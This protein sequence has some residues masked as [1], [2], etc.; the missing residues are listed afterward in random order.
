MR[1]TQIDSVNSNDSYTPSI[2]K[3]I[4]CIMS[5]ADVSLLSTEIGDDV[6]QGEEIQ[7]ER[8]F[9]P[10]GFPLVYCPCEPFKLPQCMLVFFRQ[11]TTLAPQWTD[12]C[13]GTPST[14]VSPLGH[15]QVQHNCWSRRCASVILAFSLMRQMGELDEGNIS[16]RIGGT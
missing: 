3:C 6:L 4:V 1:Y 10:A 12:S 11:G 2:L 13:S 5:K 16:L 9:P 15:K 14:K 8:K 7:G